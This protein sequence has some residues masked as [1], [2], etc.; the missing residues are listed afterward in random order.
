MIKIEVGKKYI[1]RPTREK[2]ME[3]RICECINSSKNEYLFLYEKVTIKI[4]KTKSKFAV[5][6]VDGRYY[7]PI[8]VNILSL[9][10]DKTSKQLVMDI[11]KGNVPVKYSELLKVFE[12]YL[13]IFV[14]PCGHG[15]SNIRK[16]H[17]R[18]LAAHYNINHKTNVTTADIKNCLIENG[19]ELIG[20]NMIVK[21]P[22]KLYDEIKNK[23]MGIEPDKTVP[24]VEKKPIKVEKVEPPTPVKPEETISDSII[25]IADEILVI[26]GIFKKKIFK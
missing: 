12:K 22:R 24:A 8:S 13:D 4:E 5:T 7:E 17:L 14:V 26:I 2:V 3:D 23:K 1:I 11:P 9:D 18:K 20:G 25:K 21:I 6:A 10:N 16:V 19:F 15:H